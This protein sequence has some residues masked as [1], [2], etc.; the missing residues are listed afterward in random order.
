MVQMGEF[1]ENLNCDPAGNSDSGHNNP[2][3][4]HGE[5]EIFLGLQNGGSDSSCWNGNHGWSDLAIYTPSSS[6]Q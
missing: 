2:T 3:G 5:S 1:G 6:Y 4:R